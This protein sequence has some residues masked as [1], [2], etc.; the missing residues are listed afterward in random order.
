MEKK[1]LTSQ[2]RKIYELR[3]KNKNIIETD[4]KTSE[5]IKYI[6][7]LLATKVSIMNEFK[8]ISHKIGANWNDALNGFAADGRIGDSHLHVPGP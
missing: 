5:L 6:I 7:I 1:I 8:Q 4:A 3:F 2:V